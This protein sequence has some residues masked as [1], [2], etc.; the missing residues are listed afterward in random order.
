MKVEQILER[1]LEQIEDHRIVAFDTK[2]L[3]EWY[4]RATS[5]GL[6]GLSLVFELRVL[7]LDGLK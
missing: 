1:R 4:A 6:A 5:E 2:P 7:R 3:H